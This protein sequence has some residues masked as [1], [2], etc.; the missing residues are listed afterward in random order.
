MHGGAHALA[1]GGVR[2]SGLA[3]DGLIAHGRTAQGL[4]GAMVTSLAMK[5]AV[6]ICS[7]M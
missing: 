5:M 3:T 7:M 2:T 6:S 4:S 1:H